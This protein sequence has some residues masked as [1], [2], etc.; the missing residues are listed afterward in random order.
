MNARSYALLGSLFI[1]ALAVGSAACSSSNSGSSSPDGGSSSG[2]G[3]GGG[4]SGG[5]GSGG[6]GSSGG[7]GGSG[8]G[9]ISS[10][11]GGS[12]SG[13]SG[14][15]GSG[16]GG[17]G[18]GGSSGSGSGSGGS[19]GGPPFAAGTICNDSG[20]ART[21]PATLKNLIVIML[22]NEN[23]GSV[24][25]AASA[26]PYINSLASQCG[27]ATAYNDNCFNNDNLV[28]Q[29]H[30]MALTSGSNCDTGNDQ[31]GTSC[32]TTDETSAASG[33][34]STVSI[35]QQAASWKSY[36]EEM[37]SACD[38]STPATGNYAAKHNPA[39]FYTNLTSTSSCTDNDLPIAPVTCSSTTMT[40]CGTPSNA[41]TEDLANDTL[42]AFTLVTPNLVN[43]MHNGSPPANI[44]MADNWLYTYLPLVFKSAAYLR[45]DV[46]LYL[47]WDEQDTLDVGGP[48]PNVF[49]SPYI[50][51]GT[52]TS[53]PMNHYAVLRSFEEALGIST[54]LGCASGTQ[55]GNAGAC[56]SGSTAEVRAALNF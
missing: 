45:G 46:A 51:A 29:P 9:G 32:I 40:A 6:S 39:A 49:I 24:N 28:S 37:P 22:E 50:K 1:G 14:S 2:G 26:A 35:F 4:A 21:P 41:F 30:Y 17:S 33:T 27:T 36:Q 18:S 7:S 48:I 44:T 38:T 13:G 23:Y 10:G 47:I 34:L 56:P 3:S 15:G 52:V 53:T 16:S 43:D 19:S 11:S 5:S 42:A 54:F 55:P 12:G 25:G 31:T 20:T 8:S